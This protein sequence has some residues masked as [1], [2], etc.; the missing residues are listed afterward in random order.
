[1]SE[2]YVTPETASPLP[3][4][5]VQIPQE[6]SMRFTPLRSAIVV[7]NHSPRAGTGEFRSPLVPVRRRT[8]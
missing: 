2:S 3:R 6:A 7:R 5:A 8:T 1:M 4:K